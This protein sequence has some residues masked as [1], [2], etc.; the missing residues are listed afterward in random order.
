MQEKEY[1]IKALLSEILE[2][3][4][5]LEKKIRKLESE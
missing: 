4:K 2:Y 1:A 5:Y 3:V